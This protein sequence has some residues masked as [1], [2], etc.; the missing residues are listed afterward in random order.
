[1]KKALS[2]LTGVLLSLGSMAQTI[3]IEGDIT[4]D[5]K[6]H[7]KMYIYSRTYKDSAE[8]V[9][10]HYTLKVPFST[11]SMM[12][13]LPEY[14]LAERQMYVPFGILFDKPVTYKVSTDVAKG[15]SESAVK[16]SEAAELLLAYG[17]QKS[18]AYQKMTAT[19]QAEFGAVWMEESNPKYAAFEQRQNELQKQLLLP[20]L[21]NLVKQHPDSYASVFSLNEAREMATVAQQEQLYN[22]LSK[23]MKA[24]R[25]ATEFHQFAEGLR[26]SAIGKQVKDFSLP[27]PDGK[28]VKFSDLKGKYVLIDFWASWC[29][30]CR[31]SFP[32][33]R[34]VFQQYKDQNF[35]IYSISID[36]SKPDWLKAVAEENNPWIQA[37]D[38]KNVSGSG[39]AITGVPTTILVGPDGK[40]LQ[41]EIGFDETGNG[42][43]EKQ[44][45]ALFGGKVTKPAEAKPAAEPK[46]I[47]AMP[48]TSM[49]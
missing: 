26:N 48:M 19:L 9:N 2:A 15:M 17:R 5:L 36:K 23:Q 13:L 10:G 33:M 46:V 41:K 35:V 1:M 38:D 22:G 3:T 30:P 47:P 42:G 32:H 24:T 7:N 27:A 16:G 14:I 4:G 21:Q 8:I 25:E 11:P 40:I 49:Q 28:L 34:E 37:L 44:L 6:G 12:M 39:F 31:K 29:S 43:I 20:L 18:A 45:Q